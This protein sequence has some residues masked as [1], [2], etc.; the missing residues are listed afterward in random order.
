M[1]AIEYEANR[2]VKSLE[3]GNK[4]VQETRL[5]DTNSGI[6]KTTDLKKKLTL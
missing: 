2:Q 1:K 6:T 5:F 3:S 4:I